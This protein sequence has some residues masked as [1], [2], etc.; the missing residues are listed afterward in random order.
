MYYLLLK[1]HNKTGLKYLCQTKRKDPIRYSGSGTRWLRHLNK[2]G[3]DFSTKIL[4]KFSKKINLVKN[5]QAFSEKWNVKKDRN[6]ANLIDEKGDGGDTSKFIDYKNMKAMPRGLW[7]RPDLT[8]Y[9]QIRVNPQKGKKLSY[10]TRKKMSKAQKGRELSEKT[11]KKISE[12]RMGLKLS[13]EAKVSSSK[14]VFNVEGI[15]KNLIQISDKTGLSH[16]MLLQRCRKNTKISYK[17]L[18]EPSLLQKLKFKKKEYSSQEFANFLGI[19]I[20]T[21]YRWK[22]EFLSL[23]EMYKRKKSQ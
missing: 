2:N 5:G 13:S 12:S 9:N 19:N 15:K 3:Y 20:K 16:A 10:N 14:Y 17:R 6:F 11:K 22:L 21:Y 8:K 4:G 18:I 23:E 7:K 1:T